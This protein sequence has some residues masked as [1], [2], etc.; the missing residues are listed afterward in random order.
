MGELC[1]KRARPGDQWRRRGRLDVPQDGRVSPSIHPAG[2]RLRRRR[3]RRMGSPRPDSAQR[4]RRAA[5][6][7]RRRSYS[8]DAAGS[9]GSA[10][11]RVLEAQGPKRHP[12]RDLFRA[13]DDFRAAVQIAAAAFRLRN[14]R[15][16]DGPYRGACGR[17]GQKPALL[18]RPARA[19]GKRLHRHAIPS[20]RR[21]YKPDFY[22]LQPT[23]RASKFP[24]RLAAIPTIT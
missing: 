16:G 20:R 8:G 21:P 11:G 10:R 7:R 1:S 12:D 17:L 13:A 23:P 22:A 24:A 4:G 9:A 18:S 5:A 19:Q 2:G 3:V 15:A 6:G 14:R